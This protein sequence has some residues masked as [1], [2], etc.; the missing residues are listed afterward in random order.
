MAGAI[1]GVV[2]AER[3]FSRTAAS[4]SMAA[5][6][7]SIFWDSW[8]AQVGSS[9]VAEEKEG[10][11]CPALGEGEE[12]EAAAGAEAGFKVENAVHSVPPSMTTKVA[13]VMVPAALRARRPEKGTGPAA[14]FCGST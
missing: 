12:E 4:L 13:S 10:E 14:W 3:V 9:I 8:D 7:R 6:R 5:V 11:V 1:T 2:D